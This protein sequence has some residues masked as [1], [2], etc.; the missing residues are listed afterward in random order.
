VHPDGC[1]RCCSLELSTRRNC[2]A[3]LTR[4]YTS[5]SSGLRI[6]SSRSSNSC[7]MVYPFFQFSQAALD[8][9]PGFLAARIGEALAGADNF[10]VDAQR[11]AVQEP[12][13][14]SL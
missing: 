8:E 14:R 5:P 12:A 6:I 9:G 4:R 10:G 3:F 1:D 2:G 11:E 7:D 13:R